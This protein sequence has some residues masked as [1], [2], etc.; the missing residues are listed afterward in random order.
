MSYS[1]KPPHRLTPT[2]DSLGRKGLYLVPVIVFKGIILLVLL[3][4][5]FL[6]MSS[7]LFQENTVIPK[8]YAVDIFLILMY[9]KI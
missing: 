9:N 2:A 8:Y 6:K 4:R 3:Y 1:Y 7:I 5:E